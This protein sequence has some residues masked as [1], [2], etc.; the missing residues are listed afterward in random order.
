ASLGHPVAGDRLYGAPAQPSLD[1]T[2][3]HAHRV[4]FAHPITGESVTVEAP[5]PPDLAAWLKRL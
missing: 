4:K 1:R 2:F 3:L 5:L